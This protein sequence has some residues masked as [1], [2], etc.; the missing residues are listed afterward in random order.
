M[1]KGLSSSNLVP[2]NPARLNFLLAQRE[3][4]VFVKC[5]P[6][7]DASCIIRDIPEIWLSK[8]STLLTEIVACK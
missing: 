6:R 3:G 7:F 8:W 2:E 5:M 1:K 4:H